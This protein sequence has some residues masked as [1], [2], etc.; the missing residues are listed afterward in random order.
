LE[1]EKDLYVATCRRRLEVGE[2]VVDDNKNEIKAK[3]DKYK[4]TDQYKKWIQE[5]KIKNSWK[6][7][8]RDILKGVIRRIG[9]KKQNKT[10]SILGY[11]SLDFKIHIESKFKDGMNWKDGRNEFHIDHII[12]IAAFEEDTPLSIINSLDNLRPIAVIENLQKSD[13]IDYNEIEIY[14]KYLDFLKEDYF[15]DIKEYINFI[16]NIS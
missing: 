13:K 6:I 10:V 11:S 3:R 8:Y 7:R 15:N 12:P 1:E 4:E 14:I 5:Y 2:E 16:S 9:Q